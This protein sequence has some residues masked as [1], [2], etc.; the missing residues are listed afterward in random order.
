MTQFSLSGYALSPLREGDPSLFRGSGNGLPPI[1][2]VTAEDD[3]IGSL[4]RLEH[5]HELKAE[6]NSAWAARPIA[7]S[8]QNGRMA[9]L[10]EDPGG[11][12]LDR[13][14]RDRKRHV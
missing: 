8:H 14:L 10:C 3:S 1:L 4:K 2:L 7:L 5:E 12:P 11:E 13:M 9:L 6:L